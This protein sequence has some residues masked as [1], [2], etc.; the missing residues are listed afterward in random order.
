MGGSVSCVDVADDGAA[1]LLFGVGVVVLALPSAEEQAASKEAATTTPQ[2][3]AGPRLGRRPGRSRRHLMP[4]PD[5]SERASAVTGQS[6]SRS[7]M[8]SRASSLFLPAYRRGV[9]LERAS[10]SARTLRVR[11]PHSPLEL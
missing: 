6:M 9:G 8:P 4:V 7:S 1:T 11:R 10:G 3:K 2:S 5:G